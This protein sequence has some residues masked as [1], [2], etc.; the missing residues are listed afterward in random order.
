[1]SRSRNR[2]FQYDKTVIFVEPDNVVS[3]LLEFG[4]C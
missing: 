1:M 3:M 2:Y 4:I